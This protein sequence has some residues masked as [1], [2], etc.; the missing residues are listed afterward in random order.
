MR[1][2]AALLPLLLSA[3]SLRALR[4]AF[5]RLLPALLLRPLSA[6]L[7]MRAGDGGQF[8]DPGRLGGVP[9]FRDPARAGMPRI[10]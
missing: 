9:P 2:S 10:K 7:R 1:L 3:A 5:V 8:P 6:S 4:S